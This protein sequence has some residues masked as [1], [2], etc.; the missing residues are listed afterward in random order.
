[1]S[2]IVESQPTLQPTPQSDILIEEQK[3]TDKP[4]H[5]VRISPD[6]LKSMATAA[7]DA[8]AGKY[9][10]MIRPLVSQPKP[11][12]PVSTGNFTL[13]IKRTYGESN[14]IS[15]LLIKNNN[16][17]AFVIVNKA[18][19]L[20]VEYMDTMLMFNVGGRDPLGLDVEGFDPTYIN[21]T[22]SGILG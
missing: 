4:I 14:N 15:Y 18:A 11:P 19:M 9:G 12:K 21:A 10:P 22:I 17:L 5:K 7:V 1:M 3:K 2:A 6:S 20:G 8:Y 13:E 16:N